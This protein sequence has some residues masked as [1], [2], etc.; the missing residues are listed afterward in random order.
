MI[1]DGNLDA[2]AADKVR[3]CE[4]GEALARPIDGPAAIQRLTLRLEDSA[5]EAAFEAVRTAVDAALDGQSA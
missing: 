3:L 1:T 4:P 2:E 5:D